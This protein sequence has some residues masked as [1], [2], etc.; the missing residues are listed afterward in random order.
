MNNKKY[1][2]ILVILLFCGIRISFAQFYTG[3]NQSFGRKHVQW[4]PFFWSYY[5]FEKFDTYFSK[6]G[7]N[8]A[9][10][11]ANYAQNHIP[12]IEKMLGFHNT[13]RLQFIIYNRLSDYK[14][15]NIGY[16]DEENYNT[17]GIT[18]ISDKKI[19]LFFN[20]DYVDFERQIKAGIIENLIHQALYGESIGT[21][22][23]NNTVVEIPNWLLHGFIAYA[24]SPWSTEKDNNLKNLVADKSFKYFEYADDK[25]MQLIGHSFWKYLQSKYGDIVVQRTINNIIAL[26]KIDIS[27]FYATS[28]SY[29][30]IINEWQTYLKHYY[31]D[32]ASTTY[33]KKNFI[34]K[35]KQKDR[36]YQQIKIS[37]D[38]KYIAYVSNELGKAKIF[39]YNN[40]TKKK[41]KIYQTGHSIND[42]P[43]YSYPA[44]TWHPSG[45]VL[46][47]AAEHKGIAMIYLYDITTKK[48]ESMVMEDFQKILNISYS[49][50][51]RQLVLSAVQAGQSDIFILNINSRTIEQITNDI[52]DDANPAFLGNSKIVFSSNRTS[53][54]IKFKEKFKTAPQLSENHQI[55]IYDTKKKNN[56]LFRIT[57]DTTANFR[58]PMEY[59][60]ESISFLTDKS[61]LNNRALA[62]LDSTIESIDTAIHYRTTSQWNIISDNK[63]S[64]L[65]QNIVPKAQLA[66]DIFLQKNKYKLYLEP[67]ENID[68]IK[69]KKPS[70]TKFKIEKEQ[71]LAKKQQEQS[72]KLN[73]SITPKKTK[74]TL[75]QAVLSD[76]ANEFAESLFLQYQNT[77][78][79]KTSDKETDSTTSAERDSMLSSAKASIYQKIYSKMG[80]AGTATDSN[81]KKTLPKQQAYRVEYMIDQATTQLSLS[82]LQGTYQQFSGGSSPI[83][84]NTALNALLQFSMKDLMEN[85][86]ITAGIGMAFNFSDFEYLLSFENLENRLGRQIVFHRKSTSYTASRGY[87]EYN[88]KQYTN[89]AFYILKY[90]LNE[91]LLLKGTT[92]LRYDQSLVRAVDAFSLA[93]PNNNEWWAGLKGEVIYDHTRNLAQNIPLGTRGKL[94]GEYYQGIVKNEKNL[95]TLGVDIRN[96]QRVFR[97]IIWANRLAASTSFGKSKLI[98][99][100]GG[101][102][103]WL[104]PKFNKDIIVDHSENYSYQTLATNMRGF[105]QNIRNGNSFAVISSELRLPLYSTLFRRQSNSA[106]LQNLQLVGFGD[107]GTAWVGSN[108]WSTNNAI[109]RKNI[110]ISPIEITILRDLNPIVGGFGFGIRTELFGYFLRGDW[111]WGVENGNIAKKSIFYFSFGLDF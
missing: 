93:Y 110:D 18:Q 104:L 42:M 59:Q 75:R 81:E 44:I 84:L 45:E 47:I 73:D 74:I 7:R 12:E 17:G 69:P 30:D 58:Y 49:T 78:H 111:A 103:N 89:E 4:E 54:S 64:I 76:Y 24:S 9:F 53:D 40:E 3:S 19:F 15:T 48:K 55:F 94:F 85:Y 41:K 82:F 46:A 21:Q 1:I 68:D 79:N 37:P 99:Y 98:Y 20:G 57:D 70:P 92:F 36:I 109:Y 72:L 95:F 107:I 65:E 51:G 33:D 25:N 90:P 97:N 29:N 67:L 23:K 96:Y 28:A 8:L 102:D 88:C 108:P 91:V 60:N 105:E 66:A 83:Y 35:I 34:K 2:I 87:M 71:A 86:R 38:E 5:S 11:T 77:Y 27:F 106:F 32:T 100:M 56:I 31:T 26:K 43:D 80:L 22:I 14:Q 6:T 62:V 101:V 50:N 16:T 63:E 52:Y 10:Y 61:G 39:L 13:D